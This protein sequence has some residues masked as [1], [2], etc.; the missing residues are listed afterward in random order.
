MHFSNTLAVASSLAVS[1]QAIAF[2]DSVTGTLNSL[3]NPQRRAATQCPAVW[4]QISSDLS[5]LFLSG[6]QCND[7]AR[8]AIRAGFHDCFPDGGCDGSLALPDEL[9]RVENTPMAATV[10]KLSA[11]AKQRNVTTADMISFAACKL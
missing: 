11:L 4:H 3:L 2:P 1:V 10:N 9:S 8:A 7:D 5:A 6:G